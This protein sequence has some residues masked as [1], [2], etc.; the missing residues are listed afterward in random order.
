MKSICKQLCVLSLF[1][2]V[3]LCT[4]CQ[5]EMDNATVNHLDLSRFMGVWYEIARYDHRFE[6]GMTH[7]T[8]DYTLLPDGKIRVI[9]RGFKNGE[10]KEIEGK[11]KQP[12]PD[13]YPG[14]LKVT[15]F[16]WFYSD[17]YVLYLDE[18]YRHAIIGGSS[19]KY[20][21]ILSRTPQISASELDK[22]LT[23]IKQR[24]YD[25]SKLIFVKQ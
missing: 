18:D 17:Y 14:R 4:S 16:L 24:G 3:A 13:K 19:D 10:E 8:A 1:G 22:L 25:T 12:E 2:I 7:V 20:L 9:N 23:I 21:W 6:K 11:V 15:F 5:T